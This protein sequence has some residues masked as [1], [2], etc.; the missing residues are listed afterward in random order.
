MSLKKKIVLSFLI[1]TFFISIVVAF[2]YISFIKISKET[3]SL[4]ITDTIR[5]KSLQLRRHEKNF[6]LYPL[7]SEKESE[8]I[9]R[10]I[11]EINTILSNNL[12]TDKSS[13][14]FRMRGIINIYSQRFEKINLSLKSLIEEF[15]KEKILYK[16]YSNFF[17]IIESAFYE[18]PLLGAEFLERVFSLPPGHKL[19][20]GLRELESEIHLLRKNGEDIIDISKELDRVARENVDK[21]IHLSQLAIFIFLPLFFVT[22]IGTIFFFNR[23][24]VSRL[25]VL[26]NVIEKT[27]R[28]TFSQVD[29]KPGKWSKND[30][31]C[32]LIQKFND[33]KEQLAQRE[34]ELDQ[35]N[36]ELLQSKKLAAIGALASAVAHELNNPLNNIYLSI[37]ILARKIGEDSS[38]SIKEIVGDIHGQTVRVKKIVGDL[39]E[40][41][42]GR[43]P[44]MKEVELNNL[45]NEAYKLVASSMDTGRIRFVLDS[46][47]KEVFVNADPEQ[48]GRV[49][50]NLFTNAVE[51]MPFKGDL[52]VRL[53]PEDEFVKIYVSDSGTGM[54]EDYLENIFEPFFSTK[55]KGTGLGL[56]I[57]FNIIKKHNGQISVKSQERK[58][59]TFTINVPRRRE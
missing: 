41:A 26:T 2:E 28:G 42:R 33:M 19:I 1:S 40:Y 47:V 43:E 7:K 44:N 24:I 49:F 30:E 52:T 36:K 15:N 22:G 46:D 59:T 45:I 57:A 4:E 5:S 34:K 8:D 51:A 35:K 38:Q 56:A 53:V 23:D 29:I 25:Q 21:S 6:F 58:G 17:P 14:L 48:M 11:N 9:Y 3:H 27:G 16:K 37:Q 32:I 20:K 18:R 10:Y 50:I 54:P 55:N 31:V 12:K 39:L 13:R